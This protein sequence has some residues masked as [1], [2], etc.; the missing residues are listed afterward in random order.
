MRHGG[1]ARRED[2]DVGAA[3]ALELELRLHA[4]AQL[5][6]GDVDRALDGGTRRILQPGNL[7]VAKRLQLFR[8]QWCSARGNR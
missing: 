7:R 2:R 4:L 5:V 1:G 3:I 8:V 6:V